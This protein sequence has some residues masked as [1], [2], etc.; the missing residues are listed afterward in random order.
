MILSYKITVYALLSFILS[1]NVYINS[2]FNQRVLNVV[3]LGLILLFSME[4]LKIKK[5]HF[6]VM[7]IVMTN[8]ISPLLFDNNIILPSL[9]SGI[10][11][12]V[13]VILLFIIIINIVNKKEFSNFLRTYSK[14]TAVLMAIYL[15]SYLLGFGSDFSFIFKQMNFFSLNFSVIILMTPLV[16]FLGLTTFKF[17]LFYFFLVFLILFSSDWTAAKLAFLSM[18]IFYIFSHGRI[19]TLRNILFLFLFSSSAA[20]FIQFEDQ[21][22]ASGLS[23]IVNISEESGDISRGRI[24]LLSGSV[25]IYSKLALSQYISGIGLGQF[26]RYYQKYSNHTACIVISDVN[27]CSTKEIKNG[28]DSRLHPHNFLAQT[29]LEYGLLIFIASIF[30]FLNYLW[31]SS[32]SNLHFN[33]KIGLVGFGVIGLFSGAGYLS[34]LFFP[35]FLAIKYSNNR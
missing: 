33:I 8:I 23:S 13:S 27:I 31:C 26:P 4:K 21:N 12:I 14:Y 9:F 20:I 17:R 34:T 19:F 15:I 2:L 18:I 24:V 5:S 11:E 10:L 28:I 1:S 3:I 22:K 16:L 30:L 32:K 6:F 29:L 35:I 25:D 7:M